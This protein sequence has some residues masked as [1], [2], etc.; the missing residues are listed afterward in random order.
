MPFWGIGGGSEGAHCDWVPPHT[1]AMAAFLST[2]DS[3]FSGVE[4]GADSQVICVPLAVLGRI[5]GNTLVRAEM[6]LLRASFRDD[7]PHLPWMVNWLSD[8]DNQGL[9]A[10]SDDVVRPKNNRLCPAGWWL[11]RRTK[12]IIPP[13]FKF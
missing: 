9:Y 10:Y 5:C 2:P 3:W 4:S 6:A 8:L 11:P 12:N 1:V 13:G 7:L